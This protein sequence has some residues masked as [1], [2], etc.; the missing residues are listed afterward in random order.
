MR[1]KR[2]DGDHSL[3]DRSVRDLR[4]D[5]PNAAGALV[6][7]DVRPRGHLSAR[8]VEHVAALDANGLDVDHNAPGRTDRIRHILVPK[9]VG[10]ARFVVDGCFH[11]TSAGY[12]LA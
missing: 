10:W 6:T 4:S 1:T 3:P 12:N 8:P 7:D 11:V 9:D 5:L 2:H